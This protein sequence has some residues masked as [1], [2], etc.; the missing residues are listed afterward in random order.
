MY[1]RTAANAYANVGVQTG[2]MSASP[3]RLIVMLFDGARAAIAR[4]RFHMEAGKIAD[5]GMA[6]S[7]AI[8]IIDSGLRASL[9][10]GAS[11]E[12][13]GNLDA[14]Y[15]YMTRQLMLANLHN[16]DDRLFEV[17]KLLAELAS[18]WSQIDPAAEPEQQSLRP[19]EAV[20]V[21]V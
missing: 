4:A 15:E 18:A 5:K 21:G 17:D 9:D 20:S 14:L 11:A 6:I 3:H 10:H 19:P 8:E 2:A 7:K 16:D 13:T 12:L 1:A